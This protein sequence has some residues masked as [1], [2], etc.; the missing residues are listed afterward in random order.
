MRRCQRRRSSSR[1]RSVLRT[2]TGRRPGRDRSQPR[3]LLLV[4]SRYHL[5]CHGCD[6]LFVARLGV[7]PTKGTRFYIPCPHCDLTIRGS[8][9]GTELENHQVVFQCDVVNGSSP[10]I[11]GAPIVTVNPFVPSQYG[12]DSFS[13]TGAFPTMTLVGILGD[14]TFM[15]FRV[16][17]TPGARGWSGDVAPRPHSV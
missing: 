6:E 4:I 1:S 7:E 13:P 2:G 3:N 5:K 9:S 11:P 10:D 12:A 15:A 8:M 17:A 16:R 14:Q